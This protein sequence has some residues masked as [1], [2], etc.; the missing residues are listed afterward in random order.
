MQIVTVGV[1]TITNAY[2][3]LAFTSKSSLCFFHVL[4]VELL[5][6]GSHF[7]CEAS[8]A[9]CAYSNSDD[10]DHSEITTERTR[11]NTYSTTLDTMQHSR[12]SIVDSYL[13]ETNISCLVLINLHISRIALGGSRMRE[14]GTSQYSSRCLNELTRGRRRGHRTMGRL[15]QSTEK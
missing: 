5:A 13:I 15:E 6:A 10:V 2:S 1:R 4:A 12:S 11:R 7:R 14:F 9:S 8:S 3:G